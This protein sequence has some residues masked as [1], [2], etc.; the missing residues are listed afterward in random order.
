MR[1]LPV[2]AVSSRT[3]EVRIRH[4]RRSQ[5]GVASHHA[6]IFPLGTPIERLMA[7]GL[8]DANLATGPSRRRRL[9]ART[10]ATNA[11][12]ESSGWHNSPPPNTRLREEPT[13]WPTTGWL[14]RGRARTHPDPGASQVYA[15][16][17]IR[18]RAN[19]RHSRDCYPLDVYEASLRRGLPSGVRLREVARRI[20]RHEMEIDESEQAAGKT[21]PAGAVCRHPLGRG[22]ERLARRALA[23]WK[24]CLRPRRSLLRWRPKCSAGSHVGVGR[25][26]RRGAVAHGAVAVLVGVREDGRGASLALSDRQC[27]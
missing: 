2:L 20:A 16:P 6:G 17:P 9:P 7:A 10:V 27:L 4:G 12:P 19:R 3:P 11:M 15:S 1:A 24:S 23:F 13:P 25:N 8:L 21:G 22:L 14:H 18:S 5:G 26:G